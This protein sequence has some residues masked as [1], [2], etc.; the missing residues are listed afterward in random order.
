[1][2]RKLAATR[3]LPDFNV[4]DAVEIIYASESSE[5]SPVP[6]RGTV[7]AQR[8]KGLDSNF[9]IINA[10]NDE[11]YSATYPLSS[12]LLRSVK[13]M[14]RN[15]HS[16]GTKRPRRAKL[17]YLFKKDPK[18]YLVDQNT[19]EASEKAAERAERMALQRA[20]KVYKKT[21][22]APPVGP[23]GLA[24]KAAEKA[25]AGGKPAAGAAA[26]KKPAAGKK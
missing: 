21:R 23:G 1:M 10:W 5:S 9:S 12:P 22:A 18:V 17:T 25:A 13:V 14:M 16:E 11:W 3:P 19:K 20:G 24:A 2:Q 26:A 15:R 6:V 7:I 8:N 4:G